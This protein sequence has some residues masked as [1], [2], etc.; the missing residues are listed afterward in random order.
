MASRYNF[1]K[2]RTN[3]IT[4]ELETY[5]VIEANSFDEARNEVDKGIRDQALI[6]EKFLTEDTARKFAARQAS[7][8]AP[9]T[10]GTVATSAVVT[11]PTQGSKNFFGRNQK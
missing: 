8:S 11:Q 1:S 3:A 10:S 4:G 5:Q 6:E 7:S 2:Q 9:A